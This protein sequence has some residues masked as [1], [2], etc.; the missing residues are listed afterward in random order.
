MIRNRNRWLATILAIAIA[1]GDCS[2]MTALA[3]ESG[4]NAENTVS[5]N[6]TSSD[7][8]PENEAGENEGNG[9]L[10]DSYD[11]N[12]SSEESDVPP[13]EDASMETDKTG[14]TE[15]TDTEVKLP[16]LHIGQIPEGETLPSADD[17]AFSYDLPISFEAAENLILFV[18]YDVEP[19]P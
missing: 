14:Q 17:D 6:N 19:A 10:S 12:I 11:E 9:S 18:N 3:T 16:A 5:E 1:L 2:G 4:T 8:A 7:E 13:D 15:E